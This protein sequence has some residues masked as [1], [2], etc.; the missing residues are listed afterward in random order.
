M[1]IWLMF[2]GSMIGV[3][4]LVVVLVGE[5][6]LSVVMVGFWLSFL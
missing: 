3:L 2:V 1:C 4:G 6:K 5:V